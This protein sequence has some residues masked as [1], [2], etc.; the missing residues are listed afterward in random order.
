MRKKLAFMAAAVGLSATSAGAQT[1][2][3][4]GSDATSFHGDEAYSS[5]LFNYLKDGSSKPVV[6]FGSVSIDGAP[7]DTVYTTNLSSLS[8][9]DYSA[10]YVQSPGGCCDQ[11]R[12]GAL[13]Y[14]SQIA[15]FL[16]AG[17]SLAIQDYQGGDWGSILG[18]NAPLSVIGGLGG[19]AG[20]PGCFD[21][22][23]ITA[24]GLAAGFTQPAISGCWG[25]QAYDLAYFAPLGFNNLISS[26][27]QFASLG[28]GNWSSFMAKGGTL[29]T[30]GGVPEPG[31]WAMMLIGFGGI[32]FS[33]R[34]KKA[35]DFR[36][37]Q[38]A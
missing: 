5:Q 20:G 1:I 12:T 11:N 7:A 17:G 14:E 38:A 24:A 10:L 6:V 9:A 23:V 22:E 33:M 19:G 36:R 15:A 2:V 18:F 26:G 8:I 16:S 30:I 3:L 4:E 21:T 31:T 28:S 35:H 37:S 13:T 34:R 29:G 25:H 32:G 27:P